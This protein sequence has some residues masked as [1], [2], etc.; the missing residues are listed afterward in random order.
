M[1]RR[2]LPGAMVVETYD[3][4]AGIIPIKFD[5]QP[6][7][8]SVTVAASPTELDDFME[9]ISHGKWAREQVEREVWEEELA[10]LMSQK[11]AIWYDIQEPERKT[12]E[13]IESYVRACRGFAAWCHEYKIEPEGVR[14]GI[15]AAF[16]HEQIKQGADAALA[17]EAISY[18]HISTGWADPA[19]NDLCRG[20]L[21]HGAIH[22]KSHGTNG[23]NS[24]ETTIVETKTSDLH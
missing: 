5:G 6:V 12:P 22:N 13:T 3:G 14:P 7:A 16:L 23:H 9:L 15:L 1:T 19:A 11:L 21:R 20:I 10:E 18:A 17:A 2:I 24:T 8:P 4:G